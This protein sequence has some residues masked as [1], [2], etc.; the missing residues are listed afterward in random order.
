MSTAPKHYTSRAYLSACLRYSFCV[1]LLICAGD[2]EHCRGSDDSTLG[3][4]DPFAST[5]EMTSKYFMLECLKWQRLLECLSALCSTLPVYAVIMGLVCIQCG[6]QYPTD[7]QDTCKLCE[8]ER[9]TLRRD[10]QQ[11][12]SQAA[13]HEK[14]KNV[15]CEEERGVLSIGTEPG[16]G[17]G[18]RALLIQ[19]GLTRSLLALSCCV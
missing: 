13:L 5:T 7:R 8:D 11:W 3:A 19:T 17:V 1:L 18:Q 2:R 9:G 15:L 6:A 16:F 12:I 14:H 10:G 4:S